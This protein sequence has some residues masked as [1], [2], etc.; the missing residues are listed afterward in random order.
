VWQGISLKI[1]LFLSGLQN[2]NKQYYQAAKVDGT[3]SWRTIRKITLPLLS[4]TTLYVFITSVITAFKAYA[5]VVALFGNQYGPAGDDSKMMITI[6]GYMMDSMGD[7]LSPGS[8]SKASSAAMILVLMVMIVTAV[9]IK[10]S[11]KWVHYN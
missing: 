2:I 6:V 4:P 8:I 5:Q 1:I 11:K 3:S 9:Q 7:Y 10:I